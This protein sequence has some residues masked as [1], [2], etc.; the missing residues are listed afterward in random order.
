MSS[1]ARRAEKR[2]EWEAEQLRRE[3]ERNRIENLSLY[4]RIEEFVSDEQ[5]KSILHALA[6]KC[7]LE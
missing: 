6:E 3:A 1:P 7:G 4:D 5:L 2:K